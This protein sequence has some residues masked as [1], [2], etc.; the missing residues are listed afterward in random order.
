MQVVFRS[1]CEETAGLT[2][3][4]VMCRRLS[5]IWSKPFQVSACGEIPE[6]DPSP[7]EK[8]QLDLSQ[9]ETLM[10]NKLEVLMPFVVPLFP[11]RPRVVCTVEKGRK[12]KL[13]CSRMSV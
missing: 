5:V 8:I 2:I 3:L 7:C 13:I 4:V 10:L 11:Q 6:S 12:S 1:E 9:S